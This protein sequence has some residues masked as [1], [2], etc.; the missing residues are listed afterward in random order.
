MSSIRRIVSSRINGALSHGPTTA[1]GKR[2]AQLANM[3]HGLL[4]KC[5]VIESESDEVFDMV[6]DQH[7]EYFKPKNAIEEG[8]IE[9]I[10]CAYWR[11]RR[12]MAIETTMLNKNVRRQDE[13][14]E[15]DRLEQAFAGL[16]DTSKFDVLNRYET[17]LQRT[18]QRALRNLQNLRSQKILKFPSVPLN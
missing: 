11:L 14:D 15:L 7:L 13:N 1:L 8:M 2:R 18:Y 16:S 6:L 12:V 4:S 3:R 5:V 9:D 10:A 17:R